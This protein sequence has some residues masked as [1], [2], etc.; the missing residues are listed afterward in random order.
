MSHAGRPDR[1]VHRKLVDQRLVVDKAQGGKEDTP[2]A[3]NHERNIPVVDGDP[4][5]PKAFLVVW[6]ESRRRSGDFIGALSGN[7]AGAH[8]LTSDVDHAHHI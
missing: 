1:F 8:Q 4:S 2:R 3:R 5:V 7:P 6:R